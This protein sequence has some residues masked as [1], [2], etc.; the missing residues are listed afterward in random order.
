MCVEH[1]AEGLAFC[2]LDVL[3]SEFLV[4]RSLQ[5]RVFVEAV[6]ACFVDDVD[7]DAVGISDGQGAVVLLHDAVGHSLEYGAEMYGLLLFAKGVAR[8]SET[9]L[10][11]LYAMLKKALQHETHIYVSYG[12][13]FAFTNRAAGEAYGNYLVG[14]G[15][16]IFASHLM[17]TSFI[18]C[19]GNGAV[20]A[21]HPVIS[22]HIANGEVLDEE[23]S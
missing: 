7:G 2:L 23:C 1:F 21:Q 6:E 19:D 17:L 20:E 8:H 3:L 15:H 4:W 18:C 13:F 10:A 22:G 16:E 9:V 12:S 5:D 11:C 14:R